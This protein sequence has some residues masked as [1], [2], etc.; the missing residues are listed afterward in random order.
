MTAPKVSA[1]ISAGYRKPGPSEAP[2]AL[3]DVALLDARACAAAVTCSASHWHAEVAAGRAP[4]PVIRRPRFT[5]WRAA[6]IRSYL[7][8]LAERGSDPED[9]KRLISQAR[10]ASKKA[11]AKRRAARAQVGA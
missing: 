8:R 10:T 11:Q 3:A 5:R 6:D 1:S 9:A 4:Q 2:G 7:V